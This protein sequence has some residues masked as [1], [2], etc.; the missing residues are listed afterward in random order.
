MKKYCLFPIISCVFLVTSF[1]ILLPYASAT[2][3]QE[4]RI[5][6]ISLDNQPCAIRIKLSGET[7]Y[8]VVQCDKKELLIAFKHVRFSKNVLPNLAGNHLV[9]EIEI[10]RLADHVLTLFIRTRED[11]KKIQPK[12]MKKGSTLVV[13]FITD[14]TVKTIQSRSPK[15]IEDTNREKKTGENPDK[16]KIFKISEFD[17]LAGNGK[18]SSG[19]DELFQ[20]IKSNLCP[21]LQDITDAI[22]HCESECWQDAFDIVNRHIETKTT[23]QSLETAYFLRA[24]IFYKTIGPD[25][26]NKF[27]EAANFFR[28]AVNYFPESGLVPYGI[29]AL[30]KIHAV[31]RNYAEAKVYFKTILE[32]HKDYRAIPEVMLEMGRVDSKKKA[33]DG[34]VSIFRKIISDYPNSYCAADASLELGKALFE[35][36]RFSESLSILTQLIESNPQKIYEAAD[37]LRYLGNAYYQTGK[38]EMALD[39]LC[40]AFSY[41]PE[42]ESKPVILTRIGDICR[43]AKQPE[44]A[45]EIYKLVA[46]N[47]PGSDGFVISSMRLAENA[48]NGKED[49]YQ[50]IITDFPK[51]P[52]AKLAM[53]KLADLQRSS[54]QNEKSIKTVKEFLNRYPNTLEKE[55]FYIMEQA[56]EVLLSRLLKND[57]YAEILIRY[58]KDKHLFNRFG[59]SQLFLTIGKAYLQGHLYAQAAEIFKKSYMFFVDDNKPPD[60]LFCWG[61]ALHESDQHDKAIEM[62]DAYLKHSNGK[63]NALEA[64]FRKGRIF[65]AKKEYKKAIKNFEAAYGLSKGTKQKAEIL[66]EEAAGYKEIG[67]YAIASKLL[68]EAINFMASIPGKDFDDISLA[69]RRLGQNY[70]LSKAYLKAADAFSMAVKFSEKPENDPDLYFMIGESYLKGNVFDMAEEAY[71]DII[72]IG[73]PFWTKLAQEKIRYMELEKKLKR[74]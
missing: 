52:M 1:S 64:N 47:Y 4:K 43:D 2:D 8:K 36:D 11:L 56:Y 25:D 39:A 9:K 49:I 24:Y 65:L 12:W 10:E 29:A 23:D 73:N 15:K 61:V 59:S 71:R 51:N 14:R 60:L 46:R 41:F 44:K 66:I 18:G 7:P 32:K 53:L 58:E 69:Y 42:T 62:L 37:L 50:K 16:R 26:E 17:A 20:Q 21:G 27:W 6:K 22:N 34:A 67:G 5:E 3:A 13:D 28:E 68:I 48:G 70:L 38:H 35:A 45:F 19:I 74:A 57:N 40:R 63:E 55:A 72:S 33:L 30:G 31:L 54:G